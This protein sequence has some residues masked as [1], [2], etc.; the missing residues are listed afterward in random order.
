M[1][2]ITCPYCGKTNVSDSAITCPNC[3]FEIKEWSEKIREKEK[4]ENEICKYKKEWAEKISSVNSPSKPSLA[5]EVFTYGIFPFLTDANNILMLLILLISIASVFMLIIGEALSVITSAYTG[6][7]T[8][9]YVIAFVLMIGLL[10][11]LLIFKVKEG[12][13]RYKS[14]MKK[15]DNFREHGIEQKAQINSMYQSKIEA[16]QSK[17]DR[18][19]K[20]IKQFV[21]SHEFSFNDF[22]NHSAGQ[23]YCTPKASFAN[24]IY[25]NKPTTQIKQREKIITG[26]KAY[27]RVTH[28][29]DHDM[30]LADMSILKIHGYSVSKKDG[31]SEE[32]RHEILAEI[33]DNYVL[34]KKEV[35]KYLDFFI[36]Q[37]RGQPRYREAIS[38]WENDREFVRGY[39]G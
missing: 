2:L 5:K 30:E 9:G 35:I 26:S 21:N 14:K 10:L 17:C 11:L 29:T 6:N 33:I 27:T 34:S 20:E 1:A 7:K 16:A 4:I 3:R 28:T 32:R 18:I 39:F 37:R 13:D 25:H 38:K 15:Y 19:E 8:L 24:S 36:A 23:K 31:L 12:F 22:N